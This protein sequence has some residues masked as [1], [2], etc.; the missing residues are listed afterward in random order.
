MQIKAI[1]QGKLNPKNASSQTN[2]QA[3]SKG[4]PIISEGVANE[5]TKP[6][7]APA[8]SSPARAPSQPAGS[9]AGASSWGHPCL[10]VIPL[11]PVP[12]LYP[13]KM[14]ELWHVSLCEEPGAIVNFSFIFW[15]NQ[16]LSDTLANNAL[17][18]GPRLF[19]AP[20]SPKT[21]Q[22]GPRPPGC[23]NTHEPPADRCAACPIPWLVLLILA[24]KYSRF[25][26]ERY[27]IRGIWPSCCPLPLTAFVS[28]SPD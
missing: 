19:S 18:A 10:S 4:K 28:L 22:Q 23:L 5:Q 16:K 17:N 20:H 24:K 8:S 1:L 7:M 26:A 21:G 9:E 15:V 13:I 6:R 14:T 11:H 25:L 12:R 3:S 2:K 27:S